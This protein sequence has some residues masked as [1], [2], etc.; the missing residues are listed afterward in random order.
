MTS[1]IDTHVTWRYTLRS[2]SSL[3]SQSRDSRYYTPLLHTQFDLDRFHNT[4]LIPVPQLPNFP[5]P[6]TPKHWLPKC[7]MGHLTRV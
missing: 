1:Q 7:G 2:Q 3:R 5:T 6:H 4:Q